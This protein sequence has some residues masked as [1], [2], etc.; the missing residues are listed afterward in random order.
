MP[1]NI[2]AQNHCPLQSATLAIP[3]LGGKQ[4]YRDAFIHAGWRIQRNVLTGTYRLL[5][6]GNKRWTSGSYAN[7]KSRFDRLRSESAIK[8]ATGHLVLMLHGIA[9]STGTFRL[10]KS[11]LGKK[12]YDA[13]AVSYPST[14]STIQT[15]ANGIT[16]VL[17]RLEETE[18][19]SFVTHS[20]GGL[21]L[22]VLL[23]QDAPWRDRL[24]VGHIVMIAPPNQG[25][26]IAKSLKNNRLFKALYGPAGQQLDPE[27]TT[28][29]PPLKNH[30]F[31]VI[32]GGR[33]NG[34]GFNPFLDGDNDGTVSVAE[35]HLKGSRDRLVV[36]ELHARITNHPRT[37]HAATAF[38]ETGSLHGAS[39]SNGE[40]HA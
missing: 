20:M 6:T 16:T 40:Y 18:S 8:P 39:K 12:G 11:T 35:T 10:L 38:L 29:L 7:C 27:S 22:R 21:I 28:R 17:N 13:V 5:D 2:F 25:S 4:F 1:A 32:A 31:A 23:A 30:N 26:A 15:H 34:T 3:T 14:C 19:V 37:V 24:H 36:P 33:D 9:R